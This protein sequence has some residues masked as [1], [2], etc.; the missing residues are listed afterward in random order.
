VREEGAD[1]ADS[2]RG[3]QDESNDDE[4]ETGGEDDAPTSRP[5][6]RRQGENL[7]RACLRLVQVLRDGLISTRRRWSGRVSCRMD[8]SELAR[9]K[10]ELMVQGELAV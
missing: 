4:E 6:M 2:L 10:D 3:G 8:V 9:Q 7:S 5:Y 1:A